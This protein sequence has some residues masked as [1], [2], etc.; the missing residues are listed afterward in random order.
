MKKL[1]FLAMAMAAVL[2]LGF[3][4]CGDDDEDN[5]IELKNGEFIE[6]EGLGTDSTA[7]Y[8]VHFKMTLENGMLTISNMSSK[9]TAETQQIPGMNNRDCPTS[10]KIA[11]VGKVKSLSKIDEYPSA[12]A[13]SMSVAAAE[14]HGYVIEAHGAANFDSYGSDAVHDITSQYTRVWLKEATEDGFKVLYEF[15]FVVKD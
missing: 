14:G 3:V 13:Y 1:K 2:T 6:I 10:A 7:S 9:P 4:S 11:D 15:P 8:P 5:A 12:S